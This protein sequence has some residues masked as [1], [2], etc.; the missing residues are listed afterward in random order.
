MVQ[1]CGG[2]SDELLRSELFGHKRGAYR[3]MVALAEDGEY[4][5]TKHMSPAILA[6]PPPQRTGRTGYIAQGKTLKDKV[7]SLEKQVLN[8]ALTRHRWN[9]S[10]AANEL[11]L[12]RVGLANK[13]KRY[14]LDQPH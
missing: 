12:S 6:A 3:R 7:E 1:N 5:T 10:R 9:Q 2:M 14:A 11:G 8:E 4:L 13:I